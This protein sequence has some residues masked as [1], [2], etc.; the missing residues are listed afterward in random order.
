MVA[1]LFYRP[2]NQVL[3]LLRRNRLSGDDAAAVDQADRVATLFSCRDTVEVVAIT[4]VRAPT[5]TV[6]LVLAV[7]QEASKDD[8][9][10]T[11]PTARIPVAIPHRRSSHTRP[12]G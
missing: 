5:G 7:P 8:L 12:R 9:P 1:A 4:Y 2:S 3:V 10:S 6:I 11:M